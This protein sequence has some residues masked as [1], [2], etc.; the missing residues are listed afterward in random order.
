MRAAS[1]LAWLRDRVDAERDRIALWLPVCQGIGI[2]AYFQLRA[3]PWP[4]LGAA[5]CLGV[6][7]PL[8]FLR[9]HDGARLPL[10]SLLAFAFGFT[11]AQ[12]ASFQAP[13]LITDLPAHAVQVT[14]RVAAVELLPEGRRITLEQ[15]VID[16][17]DIRLPR[18]VRVRLRP[19]DTT[20]LAAGDTVRLRAMLRPIGPP[21]MPGGWDMQREAFFTGLG[22]TG[23]ALGS[24]DVLAQ[25]SPTGLKGVIRFLAEA[26]S[27]RIMASIPGPAGPITVGILI[28]G[29][30][31]IAPADL[32]AFRDSGLAHLL[33]VSGLHLAIVIGVTLTFVRFVLAFSVHASLFW[34]TRAIASLVALAV[35]GFYTL[36]TGAQVP[37][38]RCFLMACLLTIGL[39]AGRRVISLRG[40]SLVAL[41]LLSTAPWQLLGASLQMS[42]SAVLALIAGYE[43]LRPRLAATPLRGWRRW[44]LFYLIGSLASSLLAGTATLPF[45]AYHFGRVQLYY[46]LSNMAG[47]PLTSLLVMPAGM[48]ALPL[49]LIGQ[50]WLPLTV[51]G[52]G[53]EATL[54]VA[55]QVAALPAATL[56]VPAIPS[57]GIA[58][59]ALGLCWVGLW[60]T[61]LRWGGVPLILLGLLSPLISRPPDLLVSQDARLIAVRT[62][63]GVFTQQAQGGSNFPRDTWLSHWGV[64]QAERLPKDGEAADG[65]IRCDNHGCLLRPSPRSQAAWLARSG[66]R[67]GD[68]SGIGVI[69]SSEP[70]R[71]LCDRP[72]PALVDRFTVWREGPTAIWLDA[73][74]A[75]V[76]TDRADR[77]ARLWVPPPPTPR[78]RPLLPLAPSLDSRS[79]AGET[80]GP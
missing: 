24:A 56:G 60:S 29:Q 27:D 14:G 72:W 4:W 80:S 44:V 63:T 52:W 48:L 13:A 57:W 75:Q 39:L 64:A 11:T 59:V 77:G 38:V 23:Y 19:S 65:A 50:E 21:V 54:W 46:V 10:I 55:R 36:L 9:R 79:P 47:V 37:T 76:L 78:A 70:A 53:I 30:S 67:I 7:V 69:V 51:A 22:A 8:V 16:P 2:L 25:A 6:V 68:C 40:L 66:E 73:N 17:G 3:E 61:A 34:P 33:S 28:G 42:F 35:G 5:A 45:G 43:A 26:A 12:F 41:L 71:G 18:M 58:V 15:P 31:G 32:A 74:G 62:G 20:A 49:M 1:A